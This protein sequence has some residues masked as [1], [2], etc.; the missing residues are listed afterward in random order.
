V[1]RNTTERQETLES[2][3]VLINYDNETTI[4]NN[5]YHFLDILDEREI[6]EPPERI[7][8]FDEST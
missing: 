3:A 8:P 1:L 6:A 7:D 2:G 5:C 4:F